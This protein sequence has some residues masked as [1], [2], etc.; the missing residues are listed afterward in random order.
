[1]AV[2]ALMESMV[3]MG[4]LARRVRRGGPVAMAGMA[5]MAQIRWSPGLLVRRGLR[6]PSRPCRGR[7]GCRASVANAARRVVG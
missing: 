6:V 4:R 1:M 7:R 5:R 3:L 2:M